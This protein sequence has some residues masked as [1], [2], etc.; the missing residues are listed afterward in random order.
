MIACL[1]LSASLDV[2]Y[3][4]DSIAVGEIHRPTLTV[5]VA[6]GK[7]LNVARAAKTLGHPVAVIAVLGGA[8]GSLIEELLSDAGIRPRVVR[9]VAE[10]RSCVTIASEDDGKLTEIYE[11]A[12]PIGAVAWA[13]VARAVSELSSETGWL[14][15][16]GSIPTDVDLDELAH[17]LSGARERGIR[18]AIDTHGAALAHLVRS[19]RPDLIK[20]NRAEASELLGRPEPAPS[21]LARDIRLLSGGTVVVTDGS[22]GAGGIDDLGEQFAET[23]FSIG[24]YPVGSGDSFLAAFL[25]ATENGHPLDEAL[26]AANACAAANAAEPGAARFVVDGDLA[27]SL[28][29]V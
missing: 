2:T 27:R 11:H 5:K 18:I 1:A 29:P 13:A 25:V 28:R 17:S 3:V 8:T 22:R 7:A 12:A 20:V 24:R 9:T 6:G 10:T 16:S 26:A 4:V 14:A 23:T 15:L 19:V 21:Q